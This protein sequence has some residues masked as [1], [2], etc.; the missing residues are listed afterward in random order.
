METLTQKLD[1]DPYIGKP[2]PGQSLTAS[3]GSMPYEKPAMTSS[4]YKAFMA[5]KA[6]LYTRGNQRHIG[7]ITRAGISCETLASSMVM[8]AFTKGMVNPD[9]A[10]LIR[11]FL[12]I[13]IFKIAKNQG[14]DKVILENKPMK[15]EMDLDSLENLKQEAIPDNK[16]D[17]ELTDEERDEI[18]NG[19][20]DDDEETDE[21]PLQEGFV[22][23]PKEVDEDVI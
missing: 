8:A 14:V 10:E 2:I 7:Q 13:E 15:K 17:I 16:F 6:G 21:T 5:L 1:N 4:P 11:P 20:F 19:F 18:Y 23:K 22:A 3:L 9:V 12:T